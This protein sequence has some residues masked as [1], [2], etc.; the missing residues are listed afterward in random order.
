MDKFY[1][2]TSKSIEY[3]RY[4]SGERGRRRYFGDAYKGG[5]AYSGPYTSR[6][7]NPNGDEFKAHVSMEAAKAYVERAAQTEGG[8]WL[9]SQSPVHSAK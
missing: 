3:E 1:W 9:I 7:F 6:I 2:L 8:K 4:V 5:F